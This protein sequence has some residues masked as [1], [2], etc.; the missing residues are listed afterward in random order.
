[1]ANKWGNSGNSDRLFGGR[2]PKSLQMITA[3]KLKDTCSLEKKVMTNLDSILKSRDITLS[4]KVHLVKG[5][6]FPVVMYGCE[7]WTVKK[8]E[9]WKIDAFELWCWRRLLK[10]PWT[11][12]RSNQSILKEFN[13]GCSLE[14]LMLK[15]KLQYFGHLMWRA[16]S[17]EKTLM[18]GKSEGKRRRGWQRMRWLDGITNSMDMS[19]SKLQQLVMDREAWHA[20]V[21]EVADSDTTEQL[22]WPKLSWR[23]SKTLVYAQCLWLDLWWFSNLFW[24]Q[25]SKSHG[26]FLV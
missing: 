17:F 10:V 4:T 11:S 13:P 21:H 15:L 12:T 6:A 23:L 14:G 1:M 22:N 18:L 2:A 5:M 24:M 20:A 26:A 3:K 19:F 25:P 7:S 9:H 8:A 16:D